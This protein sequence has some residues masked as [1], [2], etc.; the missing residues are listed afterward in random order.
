MG[1]RGQKPDRNQTAVWD[2]VWSGGGEGR[3]ERCERVQETTRRNSP[4]EGKA[5]SLRFHLFSEL[6]LYLLSCRVTLIS[7]NA[8]RLLRTLPFP[9][10]P[11]KGAA[12]ALPS[13]VPQNQVGPPP[14]PSFSSCLLES[15]VSGFWK[16]SRDLPLL[17]H[18]FPCCINFPFL[19][20]PKGVSI[21]ISCVCFCWN[22]CLSHLPLFSSHDVAPPSPPS[23][24]HPPPPSVC[25]VFCSFFREAI[26]SKPCLRM[27]G[28]FCTFAS[29]RYKRLVSEK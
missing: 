29:M 9:T 7:L 14:D 5:N 13:R 25:D 23:C 1:Q 4:R 26:P 22:H 24:A 10:A 6:S 17:I 27:P 28:S 2:A 16:T 8:A 20:V 19:F 21:P 11:V 12:F 15:T 18:S 3:R